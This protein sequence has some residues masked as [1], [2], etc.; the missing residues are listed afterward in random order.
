MILGV[1]RL[2]GD[3]PRSAEFL[4]DSGSE[5]TFLSEGFYSQLRV[6]PYPRGQ[7]KVMG[8]G[9]A[10]KTAF[11]DG[12]TLVL[13][14]ATHWLRFKLPKVWQML[15]QPCNLNILGRDF[16]RTFGGKMEIDFRRDLLVLEVDAPSQSFPLNPQ[17]RRLE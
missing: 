9:G 14:S 13:R 15:D 17:Q 5:D 11:Y 12:C 1:V 4:V 16:F 6:P 2:E 8:V 3:A 7:G 10:T